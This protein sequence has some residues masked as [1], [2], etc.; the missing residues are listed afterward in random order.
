MSATPIISAE[1]CI[2]LALQQEDLRAMRELL[3]A[4]QHGEWYAV[5]QFLPAED[6]QTIHRPSRPSQAPPEI[7]LGRY[8]GLQ[9]MTDPIRGGEIT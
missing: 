5:S 9:R 4:W 8:I 2:E 6:Y 1:R 3:D 7:R